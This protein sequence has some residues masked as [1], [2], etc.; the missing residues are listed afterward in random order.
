[1]NITKKKVQLIKLSPISLMDYYILE[2]INNNIGNFEKDKIF[3]EDIK[4]LKEKGLL[5]D[6]NK[7]VLKTKEILEA[8]NKQDKEIITNFCET[9]HSSIKEEL[10]N[11]TGRK[12]IMLQSK[13][14]FLPNLNDFKLRLN[15]VMISYN[16]TNQVK[17]KKVLLNYVKRCHKYK[18]DHVQTLN[19]YLFK[20]GQSNFAND[21]DNFNE[22]EKEETNDF[23]G[24]N[25]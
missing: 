12:Q 5:S 15:K 14:A 2:S 17:I 16:L 10:I 24:I 19:Y 9:L 22:I 21:Y 4:S 7:I 13:Y 20:E 11:L 23:T 25:I 18:F 3:E 1:M 8:I 6:N